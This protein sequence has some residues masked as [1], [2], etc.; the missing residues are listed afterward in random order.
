MKDILIEIIPLGMGGGIWVSTNLYFL[1]CMIKEFILFFYSLL[2]LFKVYFILMDKTDL[3][4]LKVLMW[5]F[6]LKYFI[7]NYLKSY[8]FPRLFVIVIG[9]LASSMLQNILKCYGWWDLISYFESIY[10]LLDT[11]IF[12]LEELDTK[13]LFS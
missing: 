11:Y 12:L 9:V 3:K 2:Y 5:N 4:V 10:L 8:R 13:R 1:C 7:T 6:I